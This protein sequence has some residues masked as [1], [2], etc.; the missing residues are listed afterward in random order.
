MCAYKCQHPGRFPRL[1]VSDSGK[2]EDPEVAVYFGGLYAACVSGALFPHVSRL[3]M[4]SPLS[5]LHHFLVSVQLAQTVT[6]PC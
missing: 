5:Y 1:L 4:L 6:P 3:M 2:V